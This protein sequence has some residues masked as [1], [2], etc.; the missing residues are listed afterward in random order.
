MSQHSELDRRTFLQGGLATAVGAA[1][2]SAGSKAASAA[3]KARPV[4]V[5]VVGC[6]GRGQGLLAV[7]LALEGI[8]VPALCDT[9]AGHLAD[10]AGLHLV[11]VFLD[12]NPANIARRNRGHSKR[13]N[14]QGH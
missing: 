4:R 11:A 2:L 6:G 9:D 7:L 1:V 8:E 3:E 14:Y 5:G 12:G 10:P 13:G